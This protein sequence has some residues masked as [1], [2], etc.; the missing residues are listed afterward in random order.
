NHRVRANSETELLDNQA[1][2]LNNYI[3][4]HKDALMRAVAGRNVRGIGFDWNFIRKIGEDDWG[5]SHVILWLPTSGLSTIELTE[6][7]LLSRGLN[8]AIPN[9]QEW[10]I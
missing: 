1:T 4:N 8:K 6:Y 2:P 5:L 3:H 10:R 9:S 7:M